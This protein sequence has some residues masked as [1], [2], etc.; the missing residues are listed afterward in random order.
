MTDTVSQSVSNFT[1]TDPE[2][3]SLFFKETASRDTIMDIRSKFVP[4]SMMFS[5]KESWK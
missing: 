2:F 4:F 3:C 1:S 5:K